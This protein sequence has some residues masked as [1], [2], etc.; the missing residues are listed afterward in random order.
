ML[1]AV[2]FDDQ[3]PL[4]A[5]EVDVVAIDGLLA[6]KFKAAELPTAMRVHNANSAGV[7]TRRNDRARSTR[8]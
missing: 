8:F 6:N 1:G 2:E 7:S 5:N 4:A 3:A